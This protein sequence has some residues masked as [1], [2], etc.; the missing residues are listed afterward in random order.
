MKHR[1]LV[2]KLEDEG[3]KLDRTGKHGIYE[4]DGC[5]PIQVPNHREIKDVLAKKILKD[6]GVLS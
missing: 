3:Y 2:K 4:K 6:A 1:E 5:Q